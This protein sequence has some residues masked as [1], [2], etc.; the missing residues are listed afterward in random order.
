MIPVIPGSCNVQVDLPPPAY[1]HASPHRLVTSRDSRSGAPVALKSRLPQLGEL[2][3]EGSSSK[4]KG[5]GQL[6]GETDRLPLFLMEATAT[7]PGMLFRDP[8]AAYLR[9]QAY[10]QHSTVADLWMDYDTGLFARAKSKHK[11]CHDDSDTSAQP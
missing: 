1:T 3:V 9:M 7:W 6:Y 5:K 8:R 4:W 2:M 10:V 11:T